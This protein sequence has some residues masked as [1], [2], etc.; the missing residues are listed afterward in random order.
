M[1]TDTQQK[2]EQNVLVAYYEEKSVTVTVNWH[3]Y[4]HQLLG[5][6]DSNMH[7][8]TPYTEIINR[9]TT[10]LAEIC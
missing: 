7:V 1:L 6:N 10:I 2:Y 4:L 3:L 5:V 9:M 8:P